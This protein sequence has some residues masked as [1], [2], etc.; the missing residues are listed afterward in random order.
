MGTDV[1]GVVAAQGSPVARCVSVADTS[2]S[3]SLSLFLSLYFVS[4]RQK[5]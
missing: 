4:L 1:M 5:A 2:L 3:L